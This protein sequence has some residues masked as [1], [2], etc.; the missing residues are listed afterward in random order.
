MAKKQ[1]VVRPHWLWF[2][3]LDGGILALINIVLN[4]EPYER[5]RGRAARVL[6]SYATAQGLL[7]GTAV[8]HVAEAV[9][10]ARMAQRRGLRRRGWAVQT[11]AVGFPSLLELRKL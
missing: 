1:D 9:L 3:V 7:A 5:L 10:A 2:V 11:F 8:I 6:P 4:R